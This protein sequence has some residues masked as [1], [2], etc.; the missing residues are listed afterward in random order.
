ML[1]FQRL[2]EAALK[3]VSHSGRVTSSTCSWQRPAKWRDGDAQR[4]VVKASCWNVASKRVDWLGCPWMAW[5]NWAAEHLPDLCGCT[6][7]LHPIITLLSPNHIFPARLRRRRSSSLSNILCPA[8][9]L[10]CPLIHLEPGV[11][12]WVHVWGR[13]EM[14]CLGL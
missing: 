4:T 8:A 14:C 1:L 2:W 7:Y 9:K 11:T 3:A 12:G 10:K 5:K 6:G 13:H